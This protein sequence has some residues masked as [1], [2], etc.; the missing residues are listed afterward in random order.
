MRGDRSDERL[1]RGDRQ[2]GL[3]VGDGP[4]AGGAAA[5]VAGVAGVAIGI[6]GRRIVVTPGRLAAG[7]TIVVTIR[8]RDR[9]IH[10]EEK[11]RGDGGDQEPSQKV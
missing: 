1:G 5:G 11:R 4:T 7:V 8:A 10:G 9:R 3:G 6:D 2:N